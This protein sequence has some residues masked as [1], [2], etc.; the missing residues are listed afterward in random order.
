MLKLDFNERS[1]F[2]G[3]W[4]KEVSLDL[5]ILWRYPSRQQLES[6]IAEHYGLQSDQVFCS[7]G[8][9]EAIYLLMRYIKERNINDHQGAMILPLPAFSQYTWGIDSWRVDNLQIEP[10]S[11][12]TINWDAVEQAVCDNTNA[13]LVLTS[14][15]NPTGETVDRTLLLKLLEQAQINNTLVFLD[16]AYIE[17]SNEESAIDLISRFDNLVILRTLS[18]AYGL[19]GI[20][21]GYLLGQ[22]SIIS[23]FT[24]RAMPF[25]VPA[26]SLSVASMAFDAQAQQDK[27]NYTATIK[28]NR[29]RLTNWLK[30]VGVNFIP[31]EGNFICLRLKPQQAKLLTQYL[32]RQ[33]ILVR[34]FT[35]SYLNGC[36]RIT[37]PYQLE[38]LMTALKNVFQPD[39]LCFDMDGVLIDTSTSYD[40]AIKATVKEFTGKS[41][42]DDDINR[43][44]SQGGFN[45]DWVLS[46]ALISENNQE[47][48]LSTVIEC[49]QGY[50]LGKENDGFIANETILVSEELSKSLETRQQTIGIVTGRPGAEA[51]IGQANIAERFSYWEN[52]FRM[53]DDDVEKSKPDPEGIIQLKR[54]NKAMSSWMVGDTPDDIKAALGS[55]SLAIGIGLENE[56]ALLDAGADL[57][58]D[59]VNDL[60]DLF[61]TQPTI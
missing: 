32:K 33:T 23:E 4:L 41:I 29:T 27:D 24:Q 56:N 31:A 48:D 37:I 26:P 44:R 49:F 11:D 1:D 53:S 20:R 19:A 58:V 54:Q 13:V 60:I 46:K 61:I 25:N 12:L 57:V 14:P 35:E 47:I 22:P 7:N 21:L 52:A 59:S 42:S 45:N 8:G 6:K 34:N 43:L 30:E 40:N 17:F 5:E 28:C 10:N 51:L 15:N 3:Q 16:E 50:Y 38:K 2:P 39:I 9:D 55:D 18:K 36:V